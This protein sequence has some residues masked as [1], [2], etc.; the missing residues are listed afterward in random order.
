MKASATF[1]AGAGATAL[2]GEDLEVALAGE[3]Y[4]QEAAIGGEG[5][6]ADG[7]AVQEHAGVGFEDGNIG[8][9]RVGAEFWHAEGDQI[10]GFFFYGAFQV[11]AGFVGGPFEDAEADAHAG[12]SDG[13]G[14]VANFE[15][16]L[17]DEVGY[18]RAAGRDLDAAGIGVEG[19]DFLV[20][21]GEEF[22]ALDAG[23]SV[24]VA[25]A[26]DG[27]GGVAAGDA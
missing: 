5:V 8:V 15:D 9:R 4:G 14:E 7:Q 20:F 27:D 3:D 2:E 12:D 23:R 21:L 25:V 18:A 6:F 19:G 16:F 17:V 1:F 24:H 26:L 11:D 22:E 13:R 10:R